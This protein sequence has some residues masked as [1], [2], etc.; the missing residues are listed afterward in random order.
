ME[1]GRKSQIFLEVV[2][3]ECL[4]IFLAKSNLLR[5]DTGSLGYLLLKSA[6]S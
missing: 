3:L 4:R 2:R 5:G 6:D 1:I